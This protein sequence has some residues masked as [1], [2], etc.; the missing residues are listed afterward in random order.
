[1]IRSTNE[2]IRARGELPLADAYPG[3]DI[4]EGTYGLLTILRYDSTTTIRIGKF[5]SFGIGTMVLLGGE[6]RTDWVTQYPFSVF[7]P[8]ASGVV[9]HPA[10]RGDVEIGSDVWVAAD[11]MILGGATIGDGAV[12]SA[13]AVVSGNVAPYSIVGG[14]PARHLGWRILDPRDRE[15]MQRIR[16]WNWPR[17]RIVKELPMLLSGRL[18]EFIG[19]VDERTL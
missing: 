16:W 5:S 19:R 14:N 6:H 7:W 4:G 1:M 11:A 13:R 8:E 12:V 17:E 2:A 3:Y 10:S 18:S 9:G 15:T